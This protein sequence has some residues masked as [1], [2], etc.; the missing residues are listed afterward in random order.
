[1][2]FWGRP[3]SGPAPPLMLLLRPSLEFGEC[4]FVAE[5]DPLAYII[6]SLVWQLD[7]L[8]EHSG[9]RDL[10]LI[11]SPD[12]GPAS[13]LRSGKVRPAYPTGCAG[14]GRQ[15]HRVHG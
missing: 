15:R 7:V 14:S 12:S 2:T 13:R 6:I 9:I 10:R 3:E 11:F 4:R 8:M 1:M 5:P